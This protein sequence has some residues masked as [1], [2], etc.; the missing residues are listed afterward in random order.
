MS[1]PILSIAKQFKMNGAN[2][3]VADI[4]FTPDDD[5]KY[6][7]YVHYTLTCKKNPLT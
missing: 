4:F 3:V 7:T 5:G 1:S 6:L 2:P